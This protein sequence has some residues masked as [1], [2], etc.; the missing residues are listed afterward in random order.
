MNK[1]EQVDKLATALCKA[2]SEMAGA[3]KDANNPFFKSK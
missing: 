3:V 2:Q 1:S